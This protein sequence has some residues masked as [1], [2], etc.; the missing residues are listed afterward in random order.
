[1]ITVFTEVEN[2]A[3]NQPITANSDSADVLEAL[4]PNHFLTG[5]N[6]NGRSYLSKII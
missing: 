4:T 3:N 5:R 6:A 2:M 1:M